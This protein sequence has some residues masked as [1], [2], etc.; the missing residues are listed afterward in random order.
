[1]LSSIRNFFLALIISLALFGVIAY[2]VV[3][4]VDD[5]AQGF[6]SQP[7][8]EPIENGGELTDPDGD[9]SEILDTSEFTAVIIGIDSGVSQRSEKQEA[10]MIFIVNVNAKTQALMLSPL[11]RDMKV[12][13]KGYTLRL[14]AVYA[15]FDTETLLRAVRSYTGMQAD[16]YCVLD[17]ESIEKVFEILGDVE[18]DIPEKMFYDPFMHTDEPTTDENY[19]E[20]TTVA[21]TPK[22]PEDAE[23]ETTTR[24]YERISL[25]SGPQEIDGEMAIKIFKYGKYDSKKLESGKT[26]MTFNEAAGNADRMKTQTDFIKEALKQKLTFENLINAKEIYEEIKE[27][28]VETNMEARDFERY[29]ETIFSLAE[30]T[31]KD[32][33][34][35]GIPSIENGVTFF[36]PDVKSAVGRYRPYRKGI[37]MTKSA[38]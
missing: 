29:A 9:A 28:V 27:G 12:D 16:Y 26:M 23:E 7:T 11:S 36:A 31:I 24:D 37:E 38:E 1:M 22:N 34:Y 14:G 32:V 6:G 10:D 15:E 5:S 4:F 2:F 20:P 3:G 25:A 17:Y 18:F 19:V 33:V 13:V 35:P 8:T 21:T 30:Y